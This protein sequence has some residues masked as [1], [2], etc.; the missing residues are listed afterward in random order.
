MAAE[1]AKPREGKMVRGMATLVAMGWSIW[2]GALVGDH[3]KKCS[4]CR[5]DL[6]AILEIDVYPRVLVFA[7]IAADSVSHGLELGVTVCTPILLL[8]AQASV[9]I[10]RPEGNSTLGQEVVDELGDRAVNFLEHGGEM[11]PIGEIADGVIMV[12]HQGADEDVEMMV[13]E[14]FG[15]LTPENF[16]GRFGSESGK[17]IGAADG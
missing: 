16:L 14:V 3:R 8:V 1:A 13:S 17:L 5:R 12:G 11:V 4:F 6:Q 7:P 10:F 15:E 9:E 2:L